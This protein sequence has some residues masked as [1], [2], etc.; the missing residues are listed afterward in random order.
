MEATGPFPSHLS[1]VA[2]PRAT[3]GV[4]AL[5]TGRHLHLVYYMNRASFNDGHAEIGYRTV[6]SLLTIPAGLCRIL[7]KVPQRNKH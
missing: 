1:D 3:G 2:V 7:R 4:S 6:T 5:F